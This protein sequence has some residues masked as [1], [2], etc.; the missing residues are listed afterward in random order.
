[1]ETPLMTPVS[2]SSCVIV[3]RVF[4]GAALP[5]ER[6]QR[7]AVCKKSRTAVDGRF[8]VIAL[9]PLNLIGGPVGVGAGEGGAAVERGVWGWILLNTVLCK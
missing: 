9:R 7:E 1:M 3:S 8:D 2:T 5:T 4:H 6:Q